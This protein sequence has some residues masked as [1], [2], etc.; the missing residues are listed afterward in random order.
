MMGKSLG[1]H[2][3]A[4]VVH[5][6]H[7]SF[8]WAALSHISGARSVVFGVSLTSPETCWVAGNLAG[9][10]QAASGLQKLTKLDF[11]NQ[12]LT[13]T[14]PINV[15]FPWLEELRLVNNNIQVGAQP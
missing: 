6:N 14:F 15:N 11:T 8:T 3:A 2:C 7:L 13:G 5:C 4:P 10:L 1:E 9:V 12:F